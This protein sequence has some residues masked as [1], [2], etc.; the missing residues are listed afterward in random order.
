MSE[1]NVADRVA[2]QAEERHVLG[3][4]INHG[5]RRR[6]EKHLTL[7][8]IALTFGASATGLPPLHCDVH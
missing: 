5:T 4:L 1:K 6:F 2:L 8:L 7:V 3:G